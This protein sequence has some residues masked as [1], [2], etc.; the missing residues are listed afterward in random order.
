M[1]KG[2]FSGLCD[3]FTYSTPELTQQVR[4][5]IWARLLLYLGAMSS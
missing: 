4:R 1:G 3:R 2:H 5:F